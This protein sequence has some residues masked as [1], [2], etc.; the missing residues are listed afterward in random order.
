MQSETSNNSQERIRKATALLQKSYWFGLYLI[1]APLIISFLVIII[2]TQ[3]GLDFYI[4]LSFSVLTFMFTFL[5]FYKVYDKYRKTPFFLNKENNL[6]ARIQIL[7]LISILSFIVT[8]IF[9]LISPPGTSFALLPLISYAVLYNIVYYYYYFQPIDFF[10]LEEGTFKHTGNLKL[11]V[12]QPYNFT[13]FLNYLIHLI[14]LG[15][16][17]FTDFSWLFGLISNLIFYFITVK[18]TKVQV[19]KIKDLLNEKK[20]IL[21]ELTSFKQSF[22][23]SIVSLLFIILIQMPFVIV[24]IFSLLGVQYSSLELISTSFL[25]II[26]VLFYFKSRFYVSVYYTSKLNLF[27]MAEKVED[28]EV[29]SSLKHIKY[30]KQNSYVSGILILLITI[31]SFL[32]EF[33]LLNLIILPFLFIIL[34]YEQKS[35]LC[36]KEYNRFVVIL[37]TIAL[38]ITIAFGIIPVILETILLNF[39]VFSLSLYFILQVFVKYEYFIKE[40]ILVYQN[41]LAMASFALILYSFFPIAIFEYTAFTSDPLII[42]V[43]N[44]LLHSL[45]I[46]ITFLISLY[47]LGVRY[48]YAKS[49]KLFRR[50]IVG[51]SFLIELA[52]FTFI[53][54]RYFFVMDFIRFLLVICISSILFP[55]I[56]LVFL[57]INYSLNTFPLEYF[58]KLS[59]I[60][61]WILLVDFFLSLLVISLL[62]TYFIIIIIIDFLISS[63]FYYYILKFG[64]KLERVNE[65]KFKKYVKINSYSITIELLSLFFTIFFIAFQAL[66]LFENIIYSLYLSLALVCLLIN[67]F[68]KKEIFSEGL[69]F[70]INTFILLYSSLIAFY[71]FLL[72]TLDTFYVFI[73]PLMVFNIIFY[74]PLLYLRKKSV[75]QILTSKLLKINSILFSVTLSLIPTIRGLELYNLGE[76]FDII[77]LIMTVINF[78]LY[79]DFTI[80]TIYYFISRKIKTNEERVGFFQKVQVLITICIGITTIF[81]YPFFLLIDTLYCVVLP[82]I[83]MFCF[84][85]IPLYYS[86]KRVIFNI[87]LIKKLIVFNII[88]LTGLFTSIPTII[89]VNLINLGF[90]F[91]FNSFVLNIMNFST[92]IFYIFLLILNSL[93]KKFEIKQ[94]YILVLNRLRYITIFS[95]SITTIFFY[96]F[97]LLYRTYYSVI[98]PLIALL[99]SWFF[100]F[101][102]SYK[103]EYFNLEW[104]KRLTIYNFTGLS[105]LI[106]SLPTIIGLELIRI[107]FEANIILITTITL[108][109]LFIF[110]KI[111][112]IISVKVKL[113]ENYIRFFKLSELVSWFL[114][115]LL[116]S[117]YIASIFMIELVLTPTNLLILSCSLFVFFILSVYTLVLVSSSIPKLSNLIKYQDIIIYG[118]I[119]SISSIFTFLSLS[120]N[121]FAFIFPGLVLLESSMLIGFFAT[122]FLLFLILCDNFI[123]FKLTQVK[124]ICE[125]TTWLIIKIILCI[126]ISSLIEIF[127]YQFFIINKIFLF[128]LI[129]TFLTPISLS[130]LENSRFISTKN[131]FLMKKIT[132]IAFAIFLLSLYIEVLYILT[133]SIPIF[134]QNTLLQITSITANLVIFVYYYFL[135]FNEVTEEPSTSKIYKLYFLSSILFVCLLYSN[136]ILMIFLIFFSYTIV[137]SQRSIIPI[138]RFLLYFLLSFVAFIE[139]IIILNFYEV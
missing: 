42:F 2:F 103:K 83:F 95:I 94:K 122:L 135:R 129:F 98:I 46:S 105:S 51:F 34:H 115:S 43:S 18:T 10:N 70:K 72:L 36:P 82:S 130:L 49:P 125:L 54:F 21:K 85:C 116:L 133:L 55:I 29:K 69:Y 41:L 23:L 121:L 63:V 19:D 127:A 65:V 57:L 119:L 37:N 67:L 138:T 113:K 50:L 60:S 100:L 99:F 53:N 118:I 86:Y 27:D 1:I 73:I 32:L 76:F 16:T 124:I 131:K 62:S 96:P 58:L 5:F 134:Y 47:I 126:F 106:I 90:V 128:S 104:V 59:Y 3:S 13:I 56:F 120:T 31:F 4:S 20:P 84:F 114:F 28:S 15:F 6:I 52:I 9:Y 26:F 137:L 11:M 71:S 81:Y 93:L 75:L 14:F 17:A 68:S 44:F 74:F 109:L 136:S 30:Q 80:L 61:F 7:F 108:I 8:P 35:E 123:E 24:I 40:D 25:T 12:K 78:T 92:Y 132:V 33:P 97:L 64:L 87:G 38:L 110:F 66:S 89:S 101:Y 88:V 102:Y 77:F 79:I 22:V 39:L 91:D 111:S 107:G 112:E 48:F 117:Y 139:I 45:L